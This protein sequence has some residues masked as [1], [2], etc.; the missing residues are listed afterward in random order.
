[1][2]H[3]N[4]VAYGPE[5]AKMIHDKESD[6]QK[7]YGHRGFEFDRPEDEDDMN[8]EEFSAEYEKQKDA[9]DTKISTLKQEIKELK[10]KFLI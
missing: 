6:L 5:T 10:K 1:M 3:L 9:Y 4:E 2:N 8:E 7:A